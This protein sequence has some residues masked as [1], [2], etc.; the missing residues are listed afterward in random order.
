MAL[1]N[2]YFESTGRDVTTPIPVEPPYVPPVVPTPPQPTPGTVPDLPDIPDPTFSGNVSCKFYINPCD[3]EM[4][5]KDEY[6]TEVYDTVITIK[7][8]C[9]MIDPVIVIDSDTILL[10]CNYMKMGSYYYFITV[11]ALPGGSR[12][13][14]VGK[15]DPLT[16]FKNEILMLDV[17]VDKNQYE[18]NMYIDDGSFITESRENIQLLN[19]SGGFND[20][21]RYILITAGG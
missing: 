15:R 5:H 21:G 14:I 19:F 16:S 20:S 9:S 1:N 11:E 6:L 17:I 7:D 2:T 18:S 12:Y 13:R 8:V 4:V 3:P 10:S